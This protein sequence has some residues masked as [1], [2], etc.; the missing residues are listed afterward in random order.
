MTDT[1]ATAPTDTNT[2]T[3]SDSGTGTGTVS[4]TAGRRRLLGPVGIVAVVVALA[5]PL[6]LFW[7]A[8]DSSAEITD[9]EVLGTNRLGAASI[10]LRI[11]RSGGD[12]AEDA[13]LSARDLAPGDRVTGQLVVSNAGS[14]PASYQLSLVTEPDPL[15]DWIRLQTW[16]AED[17]CEPAQ[18]DRLPTEGLAAITGEPSTTPGPAGIL[19]P[20][21]V[22]TICIGATLALE[23]P[24]EVQG[25]QVD[26]TV[27]VTAEQ[28]LDET[29]AGES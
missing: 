9:A 7:L 14:I 20:G 19:R 26:F 18:L 17:R 16:A 24:N 13:I 15:L 11:A 22:A 29:T 3:D 21:D 2:G 12:T 23:A 10:D 27:V 5:A 4:D 1:D 28:V 6:A 8:A 25:R